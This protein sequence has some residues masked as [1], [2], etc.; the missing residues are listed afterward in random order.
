MGGFGE[1]KENKRV[2]SKRLLKLS[3]KEL[4]SKSIESHLNGNLKDAANGYITFIKKG[5]SDADIYSNYALICQSKGDT[6]KA[7]KLYETCISKF[8]YHIF[9]KLNLAFLYYTLKSYKK[10]EIIVDEAIKIKPNMANGYCIKGLI[11]KG[12]KKQIESE[13]LLK[14]AI[15][16]DPKYIDAYINLGLLYKD[17]CEYIKAETCYMKAIE[18]DPNS[19]T[20]HLNLGACYKEQQFLEKAIFHT[21]MAI[22]IDH[23][24]ENGNLNLATILTEKGDYNKAFIIARK[25]ILLNKNDEVA[26][27]LISELMKHIILDN[28]IENDKRKILKDL[29]NRIDISHREIY[30]NVRN[31]VHEKTL[32]TLSNKKIDLFD[33]REFKLLIKDN[34]IIKSL[35]L[36]IFCDPLWE[37]ALM[38]IRKHILLEYSDN[39][40][41]DKE[42]LNFLIALGIQCFL[43]E[44]VYYI[45]QKECKKLEEIK[46]SLNTN[47]NTNRE[48]KIA[49]ISCYESI[50]SISKEIEYL[51]NYISKNIEFDELIN[52]QVKDTFREKEISVGIN[53]IGEISDKVSKKVKNQY[54][55]NPYP[56]WRYNSYSIARQM[57]II[58]AINSE[59]YPNKI[60]SEETNLADN[61]LNI[62]IAGCGTGMQILE[63]SRYHNCEITAIDLSISS[64]SYAKRKT[65]EYG[66]KNIN[67]IEMDLLDLMQ[68]NKKFDLIECSGVLH[69]MKDP[70]K[71]LFNLIESLKN[72]GFLKLGLYS[73]YAR[74]EVLKA[75]ELIEEKGI[76]P[77]HNE[78]RKFRYNILNGDLKNLSSI[79]NW[80]DFYS[81]SM[82]RDLCFHTQEKCYSLI[83]IKNLIEEAN[84]EFLGFTLAKDI[85]DKYQLNNKHLESLKDLQLWDK[86]EKTN[87]NTFREMYQFWTRKS[88][89]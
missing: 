24:I 12:L 27:H 71:G 29:F 82:C 74:Q 63:A 58:S 41:I 21:E 22:E 30:K 34:E 46:R 13:S 9:S 35:K 42:I 37:K 55:L 17:N 60:E 76:K 20:A 84:L 39:K 45:N 49:L 64:I 52:L 16:I 25:E 23:K 80:S 73:K 72:N 6:D 78:I 67:F 10:A 40:K 51:K 50:G 75:R 4:K 31:L 11:L 56:R 5:Y 69:H 43:N 59:I 48:Y 81:T 33:S 88:I 47:T 8:P 38:N 19:S 86:F 14:K 7:I 70:Y 87:P 62:L 77:T 83:E 53:S 3:E 44:Y 18:I 89:K 28:S 79:T 26:Y 61:K 65:S 66:M 15:E 85:K 36:M 2:A 32:E 1:R 68:L 57:N 54:E